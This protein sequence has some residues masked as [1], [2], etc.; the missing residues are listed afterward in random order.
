VYS[1]LD[2][3]AENWIAAALAREIDLALP[4]PYPL[5]R[6]IIEHPAKYKV[7]AC[8]RRAGKTHVAALAGVGGGKYGG[9]GLLDGK[10]VRFAS[11]SQ[12]QTDVFWDYLKR[13]LAPLWDAPGF[14]KNES[15]R[16]IKYREGSIRVKTGS[17]PDVLRGFGDIDLLIFDECAWL[18][19]AVWNEVGMP[20]L[21]D[22]DGDAWFLSTPKRR[23]WFWSLY[24]QSLNSDNKDWKCW[25]FP[26]TANPYISE[27]ALNRLTS[28][29][30]EEMYRQEILAEF[31]EGQGAVFRYV[32]QRCIL[33][34]RDP[35]EG[36]FV[37]GIDF[38][39]TQDY[40]VMI[41]MDRATRQ[42]VDYDRFRQMD[43]SM[44]RGRIMTMH[45]KWGL[46]TIIAERN[47]AGSP[48]VEALQKEGLP[49]IAFDTTPKSKPP[50]IESLVLAF[51][52]DEIGVL[53][54]PI[55]RGELMAYERTV[56]ATGRSQY[57][58]PSGLHDDCVMALAL[59]W[60]GIDHQQKWGFFFA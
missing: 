5:Q 1:E 42:V 40:T 6:E 52:R 21:L 57:S 60:Y 32:D 54:D 19:P 4:Q 53:D 28:N 58:A 18:N 3:Q 35:Y 50:L 27:E 33:E 55:I 41:V 30:T 56:T 47:S 13:W 37:A 9:H 39:Q 16:L 10:N 24:I 43:W 11:P 25:S 17:N 59:A 46:Q 14:Y 49:V 36:D 7:L 34:R 12:D 2:A 51:D 31:L 15:K 45:D 26:T 20:M 44:Q 8:G 22:R 23:N 29:M 48:N 38:A